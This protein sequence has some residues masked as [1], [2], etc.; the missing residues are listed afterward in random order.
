MRLHAV[1]LLCL[2]AQLQP[3]QPHTNARRCATTLAD[4]AFAR[5][6]T[7]ACDAAPVVRVEA[8]VRLAALPAVGKA[9]AAQALSK[10]LT[11]LTTAGRSLDDM[12]SNASDCQ[13][14][15]PPARRSRRPLLRTLISYARWMQALGDMDVSHAADGNSILDDAT[16]A[17]AYVHGLEDELEAVRLAA[18]DSLCELSLNTPTVAHKAVG[19]LVRLWALSLASR[20]FRRRRVRA[21]LHRLTGL[22]LTAVR[23]VAKDGHDERRAGVRA[24]QRRAIAHQARHPHHPH[25]GHVHCPPAGAG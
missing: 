20:P 23:W 18:I 22:R 4:A 7:M 11:A 12:H 24:P 10:Q 16:G 13:V 14:N 5:L 15:S 9:A 17:G 21:S 19:Y 8:L 2:C 25:R 6:C 1:K 3:D